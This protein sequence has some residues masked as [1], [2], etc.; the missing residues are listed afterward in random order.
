MSEAAARL[1]FD[2]RWIDGEYCCHVDDD[3]STA[4]ITADESYDLTGL[5]AVDMNIGTVYRLKDKWFAD[6]TL[7]D[8]GVPDEILEKYPN[9]Y[10]TIEDAQECIMNCIKT[11]IKGQVEVMGESISLLPGA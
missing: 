4:L 5:D 1:V 6:F 11:W 7:D 8:D 3:D 10:D 2:L 9:G